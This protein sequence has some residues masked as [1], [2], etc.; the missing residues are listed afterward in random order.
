[1]ALDSPW[2]SFSR[3]F[4]S[5]IPIT[6]SFCL[7]E[8]TGKDFD[9]I[10]LHPGDL[11]RPFRGV[12]LDMGDKPLEPVGP[13][14]DELSVVKLLALRENLMNLSAEFNA[15]INRVEK[16][17][18]VLFKTWTRWTYEKTQLFGTVR[19][20][21]IWDSSN[22]F[23]EFKRRFED[24][25]LLQ[26]TQDR[27]EHRP[28]NYDSFFFL[29]GKFSDFDGH[30][31]FHCTEQNCHSAVQQT[32]RY[33]RLTDKTQEEEYFRTMARIEG[34]QSDER[35]GNLVK[36]RRFLKRLGGGKSTPTF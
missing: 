21:G 20:E 14:V 6:C 11:F 1:M 22:D 32:R 3:G 29:G 5:Q 18:Q 36:C 35:D 26:E 9:V 31:S 7:C 28:W 24:R 16:D 23:R 25:R 17:D 12:R 19:P 15:T 27:E 4:A 34:R 30:I 8:T 33:A 2:W 10:C 13:L